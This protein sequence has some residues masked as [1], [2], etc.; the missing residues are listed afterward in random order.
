MSCSVPSPKTRCPLV[1]AV[2]TLRTGVLMSAPDNANK[3][4]LVT[5]SVPEE[6]KTGHESRPRPG[7][8]QT[9]L[10]R[11]RG[12][13]PA[14]DRQDPEVDPDAPG[15][16]QLMA[17]PS[18][19][20][21]IIHQYRDSGLHSSPGPT[22]SNPWSFLLKRF[23]EMLR[24]LEESFDFV[25]LDSPPVQLGERR[26]RSR[27]VRNPWCSSC[28]R[29]PRPIRSRGSDRALEKGKAHL[30]G[31]VLNQLDWDKADATTAT[32]SSATAGNT[33]PTGLRL[34]SQHRGLPSIRGR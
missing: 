24:K 29:I 28:A 11:R 1:E 14:E 6:G 31:V 17:A 12:H 30:L 25:V 22:P 18:R 16:S 21:E 27:W 8:A 9:H 7:P 34:L 15:L 23:A 32:G 13:A 19:R 20:A 5:S 10:P 26:G 4:I 3:T 2:R 33:S